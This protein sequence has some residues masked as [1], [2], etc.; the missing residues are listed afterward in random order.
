MKILAV[1]TSAGVCS[2]A[3]ANDGVVIAAKEDNRPARQAEF[4]VPLIEQ[5]LAENNYQYDDLDLLTTTIGPGSFTGIRIGMA[6]IKGIA[7]ATSIPAI[8]ISTLEATAWYAIHQHHSQENI[9]VLLNAM[10]D[11][12]YV[13][14][15]KANA[16]NNELNAIGEASLVN[17]A[18]LVEIIA[19]NALITGNCSEII[20]GLGA[21]NLNLTPDIVLHASSVAVLAG[22][23]FSENN[24]VTEK[25][26][27]LYIRKPDAKLPQSPNLQKT[28]KPKK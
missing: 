8:G 28:D 14:K 3:L 9:I 2:V 19:A 23:R 18:D 21:E 17:I 26:T 15:F 5:I 10:R 6:V 22:V 20:N 13:Q 12:V 16:N 24:G 11:Q 4:T 25:L 1:D 7:L 27:P